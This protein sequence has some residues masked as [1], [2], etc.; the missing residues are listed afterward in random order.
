MVG[1]IAWLPDSR[2][3]AAFASDGMASAGWWLFD[4]ASRERRPLW[5]RP[6]PRASAGSDS[7]AIDPR[8]FRELAWSPDG[9]H[10]AA[11]MQQPNG[12]VL[13][14]G[15]VDGSRG[16]IQTSS[17]PLSSPVW[18]PN[19]KAVACLLWSQGRPRVSVPCGTTTSGA[20]AMEAY[21][22]IAFSPDGTKIYFGSPGARGTL[23]LWVQPTAGGAPTRS[24]SFAR[25]TYAPSVS[26]DGRVLFGTQDYRTF[27]AVVP[28]AGGTVR[29]VTAFQSETP[30]WSRDDRSIAFT[31]GSWR[32]IVDDMRYPGH[33]PRSR[34]GTRK[35]GR[36]RHG[37]LSR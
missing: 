13:W 36:A 10:L 14:M 21:G 1:S 31:F 29:Q 18:A 30:T 19:G 7:V 5:S 24:T 16:R 17:S 22:P 26:R 32:R 6:F 9:A 35:R 27:I 34:R 28:S 20:A 25:D 4:A 11:I 8:Q 33:R 3:V 12:F 15:D 37:G 2:H 23:D